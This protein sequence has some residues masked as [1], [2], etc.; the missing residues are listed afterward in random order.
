MRVR[1]LRAYLRYKN[2]TEDFAAARTLAGETVGAPSA[3]TDEPVELPET[4]R[5]RLVDSNGDVEGIGVISTKT[6]TVSF[7][8]A[9]WYTT[10]GVRLGAKPNEK[11]VYINNGRKVVIK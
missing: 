3:T 8:P 11:G 5:V 7:D 10:D 1:P 4:I 6:G 9:A 2:G